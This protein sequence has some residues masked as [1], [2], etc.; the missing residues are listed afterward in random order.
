MYQ[1][2]PLNLLNAELGYYEYNHQLAMAHIQYT[3]YTR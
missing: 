2:E 3:G 1:N